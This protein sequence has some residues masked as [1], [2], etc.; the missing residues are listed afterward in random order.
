MMGQP[1]AAALSV[2][3]AWHS[4]SDTL[5]E[6]VIES[7]TVF[8]EQVE[9]RLKVMPGLMDL[10][11]AVDNAGIPKAIATSGARDYAE[12]LLA[13]IGLRE[14]F[15]T[16]IT[17]SDITR[18][19]P[20]PEIYLLAARRFGVDPT[21]MLVLE[22]SQNGCRAGVAAGAYT[23]AVPSEHTEGHDYT[24]AA[25]IAHSLADLRIR[26]VLSLPE[27]SANEE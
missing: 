20:D 1:S 16:V 8:W 11:D 17:A 7:D 13:R 4:F 15:E 21:E 5:E 22:D 3:I 2:M 18:G 6:L 27:S 9:G 26:Q 14:R 10:I 24:G 12:Q 25:F 23:V 19:K